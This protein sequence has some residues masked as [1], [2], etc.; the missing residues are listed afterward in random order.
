MK[1]INLEINDG[2]LIHIWAGTMGNVMVA[3]YDTQT[4]L[5][6]DTLDDAINSLWLSGHKQ[7]ARQLNGVKK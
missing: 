5:S 3:N 7:A 6:F 4:L 2:A 1:S